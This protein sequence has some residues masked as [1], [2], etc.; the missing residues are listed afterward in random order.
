M[1]AKACLGLA[2]SLTFGAAH[3][4]TIWGWRSPGDNDHLLLLL[5]ARTLAPSQYNNQEN[6]KGDRVEQQGGWRPKEPGGIA[7]TIHRF[8]EDS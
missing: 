1:P 5:L 3:A 8:H 7:G 2:E 4:R 6:D